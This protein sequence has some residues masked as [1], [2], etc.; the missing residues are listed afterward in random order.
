MTDSKSGKTPASGEAQQSTGAMAPKNKRDALRD[1]LKKA[2][3]KAGP[4]TDDWG[5]AEIPEGQG[6][7]TK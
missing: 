7:T 3:S 4:P 6:I 2:S 1:R 5:T